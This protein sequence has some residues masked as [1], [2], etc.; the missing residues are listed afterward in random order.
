MI[1]PIILLLSAQI[2]TRVSSVAIY[3]TPTI[4]KIPC[5]S[6]DLCMN[7]SEYS[8]SNDKR[9]NTELVLLP[10]E[11]VLNRPLLFKNLENVSLSGVWSSYVLPFIKFSYDSGSITFDTTSNFII[12]NIIFSGCQKQISR[13][14]SIIQ[15]RNI[16]IINSKF[17]GS[18]HNGG[19]FFE[20]CT[21]V[22]VCNT[23]FIGN[24][25]TNGG[26]ALFIVHSN[27]QI[28]DCVFT[29]NS[30]TNYG[31][32]IYA[33]DSVIKLQS[34]HFLNNTAMNGGALSILS[35]FLSIS[36]SFFDHNKA[37]KYGG[38]L[39]FFKD[40]T[41]VIND[42]K[43]MNGKALS[44]AAIVLY[45]GNALLYNCSFVNNSASLGGGALYTRNA[46]M[47]IELSV[48]TLNFAYEGKNSFN[49]GGAMYNY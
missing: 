27:I 20:F 8:H 14:V 38:S 22:M 25:N 28:I 31:G 6:N 11:H 21:D 30:A 13:T 16:S 18:A 44:G 7:L 40:N 26:G 36:E 12:S 43:F 10:G 35:G 48:L 37:L 19:L 17:S 42:S 41:L 5:P 47:T 46:V 3:I 4:P 39:Y 24:Q 49:F 9:N 33:G 45:E 15:S 32:A 29:N 34:S 1:L 2:P 23:H